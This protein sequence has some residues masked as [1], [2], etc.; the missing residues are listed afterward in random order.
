MESTGSKTMGVIALFLGQSINILV[1][2]LFLPY[3]S[4]SFSLNEYGTYGQILMVSDMIKMFFA[5]GLSKI[6]FYYF[7]Q[8][9]LDVKS[10]FYNNV[11]SSFGLGVLGS[12]IA[13]IFAPLIAFIFKNEQIPYL[14]TLS[15]LSFPFQI[16]CQ[17]LNGTL[18]F[19]K[20]IQISVFVSIVS[21]LLRSLLLFLSIFYTK[22]L[23]YVFMS[24]LASSIIEFLIYLVLTPKQVLGRYQVKLS[25]MK[26]QMIKGIPIMLTSIL[27]IAFTY[28][29]GFIISSILTVDDYAI[30]RNGTIEVPIIGSLYGAIGTVILPDLARYFHEKKYDEIVVLKKKSISMTAVLVIP[31]VVFILFFSKSIIVAYLSEKYVLS[32]SIF[33]IY[34]LILLIRINNYQDMFIASAKGKIMSS[35]FLTVFLLNVPISY[36]F[37][38][39]WGVYGA[40]ISSVLGIFILAIALLHYGMKQIDKNIMDVINLKLFVFSFGYSLISAFLFKLLWEVISPPLNLILP[41]LLLHCAVCFHISLKLRHFDTNILIALLD[42]SRWTGGM[43]KIFIRIYEK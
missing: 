9:D 14:L 19:F 42:K 17:S 38:L 13:F 37:V 8:Q 29:G 22:K 21:N 34:S 11:L 39:I 20:K 10:V 31:I 2:F 26:D 1:S 12:F 16:A 15:A 36:F 7:S 18:V 35:I 33:M 24:L 6:I 41:L 3:L 23:D 28:T 25:L 4:R 40:A 43:K 32:S 27:G 5:L 30:F